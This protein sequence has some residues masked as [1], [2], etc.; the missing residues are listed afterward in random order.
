M[1]SRWKLVLYLLVFFLI[2]SAAG[3]KAYAQ[4]RLP[5]RI[6]RYLEKSNDVKD[7]QAALNKLGYKI[8]VDGSYGPATKNAV[9]SFQKKHSSLRNDGSYGPATRTVMLKELGSTSGG[10]SS[11]GNNN[12]GDSQKL[13]NRIIRYLE[14][15]E[16]I[17]N[18]Q[19]ALNKLG[20]K[21]SVDGSYGPGTRAAVLAFQSKYS[22]LRNDGS[23]GP[24]TRAVMIKALNGEVVGDSK[25][26]TG[27]IAYLTFDD[28]PSK[29][30]T[31]RILKTLDDYNIKATFFILGNMAEKSPDLIRQ[32]KAKGHTIGNH[33]YSHNYSYVYA[34]VNN[35]LGEVDKTNGILRNILGKNYK[36]S[37][38]R[39]PGG[40]FENYK[41]PFRNAAE[42]RGYRIYDWNALNG[43]SEARTV[44]VSKQMSRIRETVRGQKEL[45]VLMHDTY[46]KENTATALPQIIEYLKSQGYSFRPLSE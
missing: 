7:V 9:L 45:V 32:M 11:G 40:S 19:S 26:T 13:P 12:S 22:S 20:H 23:Y 14:R 30:V 34:N 29:T 41:K 8:S 15:N 44:S 4:E 3:T 28:G 24:N 38:L 33:T 16:D 17:K 39:F 10:G 6:L 43:D 37:L 1:K 36:T 18:I 21:V 5:N 42:K 25:P 31:P 35:F 27:K 2:I 46:G